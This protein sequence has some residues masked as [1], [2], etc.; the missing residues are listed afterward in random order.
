[1]LG[2]RSHELLWTRPDIHALF[3]RN[4]S[5]KDFLTYLTWP[6]DEQVYDLMDRLGV[7]YVLLGPDRSEKTYYN[8]WVKPT[9]HREIRHPENPGQ[10]RASVR[11]R[12]TR[13]TRSTGTGR[14]SPATS[15]A[16]VTVRRA[17]A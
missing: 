14:A 15:A 10:R 13:S 17:A 9:Y 3:A 2:T 7:K 16:D 1:M 5:E 12:R 8:I 11:S 4:M 6:S